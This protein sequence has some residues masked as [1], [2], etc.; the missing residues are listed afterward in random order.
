VAIQP[1]VCDLW[2][3]HILFQRDAVTG[4]VDFGSV[5]EDHVA[6]D[7]AR[8]LG[9]LVG[10]EAAMWE[11]GFAAYERVRTLTAEERELARVLDRT[12]TI[13]AA[14]NWLRWLYHERRRYD[15]PD[16]VRDRLAALV[17]RVGV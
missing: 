2:H 13:L 16:A 7:L 1:C 14:A 4:I 5:K 17:R 6:V 11:V 10:D 9:S 8:L 3:D 12:G 15:R